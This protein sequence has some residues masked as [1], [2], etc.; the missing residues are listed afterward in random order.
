[1]RAAGF[2]AGAA[3]L[4]VLCGLWVGA[5]ARAQSDS[6]AAFLTRM[7]ELESELRRLT[8]R[9]EELERRLSEHEADARAR[10]EDFD[11]RVIELEGG[12]PTEA[13]RTGDAAVGDAA[14]AAP[15]P[16]TPEPAAPAGPGAPPASLGD[17]TIT[18]DSGSPAFAAAMRDLEALG[19]QAG[20][21]SVA[22]FANEAPD[23]P[24]LGEAYRNVGRAWLENGRAKEAAQA[25]LVGVRDYGD[26]AYGAENLLGLGEAL[27]ELGQR[28][29][30]CGAFLE[31]PIR[32]PAAAP[33]TRAAASAAAAAVGCP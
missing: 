27:A 28:D 3:T 23:D 19:P 9:V 5:P 10:F 29:N 24:R 25:F 17:L 11:Y 15:A 1:M 2:G 6:A 4:A 20:A 30:A 22:R 12:D 26:R 18:D 33:E 32:Y 21:E 31:L 7:T 16:T 8:A 13:F 14:A